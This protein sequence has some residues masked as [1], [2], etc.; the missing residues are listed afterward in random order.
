MKKIIILLSLVIITLLIIGCQTKQ[1]ISDEELESKLDQLSDQELEQLSM[2]A[3]SLNY[4][5]EGNMAGQAFNSLVRNRRSTIRKANIA[6]KIIQRRLSQ[7]QITRTQDIKSQESTVTEESQEQDDAEETTA[8]QIP[9]PS[10]TCDDTCSSLIN[11]YQTE[12]ICGGTV[13]IRGQNWGFIQKN[14]IKSDKISN[15]TYFNGAEACIRSFQD[16][17]KQIEKYENNNWVV[18]SQADIS[19]NDEINSTKYETGKSYRAVCKMQINIPTEPPTS[20]NNGGVLN[21]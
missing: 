3:D 10:T 4:I 8:I 11:C 7:K 21:I 14:I 13:L 19:C 9:I 6:K 16:T 12:N 2:D 15:T 5:E 18:I 17:C 20:G 1:E